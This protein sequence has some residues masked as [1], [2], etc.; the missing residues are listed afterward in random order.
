MTTRFDA[1]D[2]QAQGNMAADAAVLTGAKLHADYQNLLAT[3]N[4]VKF[5]KVADQAPAPGGD[6]QGGDDQQIGVKALLAEDPKNL[7]PNLK[8]L[9]GLASHFDK[10]DD[11]AK[12]MGEVKPEVEKTIA[13]SDAALV[14]AEK[15]AE[16]KAATLKPQY[17]AA[18]AK[19]QAAQGPFKTAMS[20]VPQEAQKHVGAELGLLFDDKTSAGVRKAIEAELNASYKGLVPATKAFIQAQKDAMPVV[21]QAQELEGSMQEAAAEPIVTRMIYADMLEQSGDHAGAKQV[22]AEA[23]A[24]QMGM[25]IEQ[26]RQLQKSQKGGGAPAKAGDN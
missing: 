18:M 24:L 3:G 22:Q 5:V 25:T 6:A 17:E 12:A 1:T 13:A 9:Q 14:T 19:V 11:K 15:A 23:V 20:Q 21:K 16:A 7:T 26:F 4:D 8:T 2:V 10:A